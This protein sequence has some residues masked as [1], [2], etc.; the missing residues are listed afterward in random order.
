MIDFRTLGE[1]ISGDSWV[2]RLD[3]RTKLVALAGGAVLSVTVSNAAPLA[4]LALALAVLVWTTYDRD[5]KLTER[6]REEV[7]EV[8]DAERNTR[9]WAQEQLNRI[10]LQL[11]QTF[12]LGVSGLESLDEQSQAVV[13]LFVVVVV[14]VEVLGDE[15][16]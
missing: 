8:Q 15:S 16:F 13:V 10:L 2:H 4:V 12:L 9:S 14:E 5:R 7:R 11:G 1:P 6:I 3:P